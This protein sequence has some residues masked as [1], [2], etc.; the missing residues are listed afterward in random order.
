MMRVPF[1][2]LNAQHATIAAEIEAAVRGVFERGDF[3]MGA[4]V[5]QFEAEY[6][7]F[8]GT[9]HAVFLQQAVDLRFRVAWQITQQ[10]VLTWREADLRLKLA[11]DVSQGSPQ[12]ECAVVFH[13]TVGD[14]EVR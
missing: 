9:R 4:A 6:A 1:V 3:I 12:A 14:A 2:D 5:E 7:A 10:N 11:N 8:I 13:A